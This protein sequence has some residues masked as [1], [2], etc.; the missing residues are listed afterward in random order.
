MAPSERGAQTTGS[1][2]ATGGSWTNSG[3][4]GA[5][6]LM[7][8]AVGGFGVAAYLTSVHYAHVALLCS[9]SGLVNCDKVVTSQFSVVPGTNL[10]ITLPG[11]AFFLISLGLAVAQYARPQRIRLRQAHFGW[12]ILGLLAVFYLVFVELEELHAICLWCT[13]VHIMIL[14]TVF[15]TAWRLQP[16]H[17]P[18]TL[19]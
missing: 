16:S 15:T 17:E 11:M 3:R 8:L 1:G 4:L 10:P 18:L 6:W 5:V 13:S 9:A 12:A 14:L 19:S 2:D 7:A